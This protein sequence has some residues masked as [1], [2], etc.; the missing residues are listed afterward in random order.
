MSRAL[1]PAIR[2]RAQDQ[3]V[4]VAAAAG[5]VTGLAST[6]PWELG[7]AVCMPAWALVGVLLGLLVG[8][9]GR[10]RAA[11]IGY[12]AFLTVAFLYSRFGGAAHELPAYTVF[13]LAMSIGGALAGVVT[14]FTGSRLP[15][16]R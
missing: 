15:D 10:V 16:R 8:R 1:S 14:V 4:A 9:S 6:Y 5:A 11:G 12:G 2:S 3:V 7:P 13:V